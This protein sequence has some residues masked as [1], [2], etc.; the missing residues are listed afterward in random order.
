MTFFDSEG[1]DHGVSDIARRGAT[2]TAAAALTMPIIATTNIIIIII[3]AA[4]VG[5]GVGMV[6]IDMLLQHSFQRPACAVGRRW[7]A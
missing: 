7:R 6:R 2:A 1:L 3:V 4:G 5:I